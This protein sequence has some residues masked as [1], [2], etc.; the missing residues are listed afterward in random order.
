[1]PEH[2]QLIAHLSTPEISFCSIRRSNVAKIIACLPYKVFHYAY[3]TDYDAVKFG[4]SDFGM[5]IEKDFLR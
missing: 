4:H 2:M 1:M 5:H 3:Y